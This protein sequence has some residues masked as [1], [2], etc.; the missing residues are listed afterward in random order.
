MKKIKINYSACECEPWT[1]ELEVKKYD[2]DLGIIYCKTND[3][4]IKQ[5][6]GY[7]MIPMDESFYKENYNGTKHY[8]ITNEKYDEIY[9]WVEWTDVK[10]WMD[11]TTLDY[12][13][14]T[15]V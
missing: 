13:N 4:R 10:E 8:K 15:A 2:I 3:P 6:D 12:I 9:I 11:T 7:V 5:T 14:W 1:E